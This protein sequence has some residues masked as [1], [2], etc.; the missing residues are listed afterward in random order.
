MSGG[1]PRSPVNRQIFSDTWKRVDLGGDKDR[2]AELPHHLERIRAVGGHANRRMGLL[3]R[4]GH[5]RHFS[6]LEEAATMRNALVGPGPA[7]YIERLEEAITAFGLRDAESF[8]MFGQRA[9]ADAEFH[10]AVA[11]HIQGCNLFR[12]THRMRQW[13]QDDRNPEPQ[14]MGAFGQRR[15]QQQGRRQDRQLR[16]EMLLDRPDRLEA[17]CF[18]MSGLF[19][20]VAT[21]LHRRLDVTPGQLIMK[22]ELHRRPPICFDNTTIGEKWDSL[23]NL[24]FKALSAKT[25]RDQATGISARTGL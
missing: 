19:Q 4:F 17:Q 10:P 16:I 20:R 13:Q 24:S 23:S 14:A 22:P 9:A 11:E 6:D 15:Q 7:D 2:Q 1:C 3:H 12:Y 25:N 18:S 21:T 8:E 5:D